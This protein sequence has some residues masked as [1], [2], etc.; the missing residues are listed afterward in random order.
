M[1]DV[2]DYRL[3]V[4]FCGNFWLDSFVLCGLISAGGLLKCKPVELGFVS[5]GSKEFVV[6]VDKKVGAF[7][8]SFEDC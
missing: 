6:G 3:A 5:A 4:H 8:G 7:F 2:N 1:L